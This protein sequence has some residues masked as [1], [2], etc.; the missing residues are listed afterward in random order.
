MLYVDG[1]NV[2]CCCTPSPYISGLW[3]ALSKTAPQFVD[4]SL[5]A[6]LRPLEC[7]PHRVILS[8]HRCNISAAKKLY[9]PLYATIHNNDN[10]YLGFVTYSH[11]G[12]QF[13]QIHNVFRDHVSPVCTNVQTLITSRTLLADTNSNSYK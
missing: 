10:K 7:V 9:F 5:A 13:K 4:N 6:S 12:L 11:T 3:S 1:Q 8:D 2:S